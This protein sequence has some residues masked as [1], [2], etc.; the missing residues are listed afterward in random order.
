MPPNN[1]QGLGFLFT[2]MFSEIGSMLL[3]AESFLEEDSRY[4]V[5]P[6]WQQ[7]LI[8]FRDEPYSQ[9]RRLLWEIPESNPIRTKISEGEYECGSRRGRHAVYGQISCVWEICKPT[10]IGKKQ[11]KRNFKSL[12]FVLC[13]IASTKVTIWAKDD[14][15]G[16][17]EL[18]RWTLDIGDA[19]S[20][21]CHFHTQID[22]DA[23]HEIFPKSL[24]VPRLPALLH[25]PMDAVDFLLGELFQD[26]WF[27]H[28]SKGTDPGQTW[29]QCQTTRLTNLL[30]WQSETINKASGSPWITLKKKKPFLDLLCTE[31]AK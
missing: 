20:P 10:P 2:N 1:Y 21:G 30:N 19:N 17:K 23:R 16:M 24:P 12:S 9:N 13:G 11:K 29:A 15:H 18:A 28:A 4:N 22:L 7:V 3:L 26:R 27:L 8:N 5:I 6:Q 25:T 31:P 14:N